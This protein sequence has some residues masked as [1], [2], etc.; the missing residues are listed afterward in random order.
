MRPRPPL[1]FA[2]DTRDY[3]ERCCYGK[4]QFGKGYVD[5]LRNLAKI[6]NNHNRCRSVSGRTGASVKRSG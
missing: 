3:S 2:E 5:N 1:I 4:S 6:G